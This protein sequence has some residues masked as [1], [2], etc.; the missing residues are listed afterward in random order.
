MVLCDWCEGEASSGA[1]SALLC[2][3]RRQLDEYFAGR[4]REFDIPLRIMVGTEFQR[5][6]WEELMAV[7]YGCTVSYG[8]LAARCGRPAAVRAVGTAVGRNPLQ[9]IIPCHRVVGARGRVGGY[10]GPIEAKL[11]LLAL[12]SGFGGLE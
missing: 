8:E 4:R 5:K 6:V 9:I 1:G 3:L 11:A 12:E 10:R 2:E 7:P